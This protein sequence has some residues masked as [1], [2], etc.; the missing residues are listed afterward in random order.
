MDKNYPLVSIVFTSYNH[1]EY[2]KQA[3]D[4]LINQ[5]YPNL[6][7]IIIDDC[8]TDGSQEVLKQYEHHD[9]IVL[10]LQSVNSG[11]YVNSSNYG[12]EMASGEYINFAQCDD[13]SNQNQIEK[14]VSKAIEFP[15]VGVVFSKSYLIDSNGVIIGDD[16]E[17]R[18]YSFREKCLNSSFISGDLMF[19]FLTY[20]CVIPNLS[21]ALIKR[22]LLA[23]TGGLSNKYKVASDWAFWLELSFTTNFYYISKPLNY[24]RQHPT[25][26]RNVIK[27]EYQVIELFDIFYDLIKSKNLSGK[28]K[29][30]LYIGSNIVWISGLINNFNVFIITFKPIVKKIASYNKLNLI[31]LCLCLFKVMKESFLKRLKFKVKK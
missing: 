24:F 3:L 30:Q 29:T 18:E 27:F 12:A 15:N 10:K 5:T 1:K 19:G 8:S 16:Y 25:T 11:S 26:I 22:D 31:Y 13:F 2:L 7:I 17:N 4:S 14:L 6:E 20:S 21:S 9:N 23:S 28:E